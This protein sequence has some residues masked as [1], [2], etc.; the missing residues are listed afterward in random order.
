MNEFNARLE[1]IPP[2]ADHYPEFAAY[3]NAVKARYAEDEV[4]GMVQYELDRLLREAFSAARTCVDP[5]QLMRAMGIVAGIDMCR[6]QIVTKYPEEIENE[7]PPQ[8]Q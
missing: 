3:I 1:A 7:K 2:E 4:G 5:N 6:Q 8:D